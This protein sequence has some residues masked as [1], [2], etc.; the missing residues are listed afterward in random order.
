VRGWYRQSDFPQNELL[1]DTK[2]AATTYNEWLRR[3]GVR[4]VVLSDS[5]PDYSSRTE[6]ALIHAGGSRLIPVFRSAHV[7]IYAVP[8]ATPIVTGPGSASVSWLYPARVVFVV[9]KPGTYR[10]ALRWSPYW[11]SY[12]G[13]VGRTKD[14][15]VR[16]TTAQAGLVDLDF[17]LSVQRGLETLAG[18]KPRSSCGGSPLK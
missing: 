15:M 18:I 11:R 12:Q 10:V 17:R 3:L 4:Y 8:H 16:V 7:T 2:L 1:Y 6:A 9:D 13:C 5:A 14:G